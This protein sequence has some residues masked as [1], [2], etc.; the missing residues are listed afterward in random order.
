VN[1]YPE[2]IKAPVT[3]GKKYYLKK[4]PG[5][6][7][8][9][10][11]PTGKAQ[12]FYYWS[13]NGSYYTAVGGSV[14]VNGSTTPL[15]NL[16][17]GVT[18]VG[19]A[20]YN[21]TNDHVLFVCDGNG[22]W[23]IDGSNGVTPIA[24]GGSST[25]PSPHIP[26]PVFLDGYIFLP[27]AGSQLIYNSSLNDPTGW[28]ADG[29]IAA[30]MFPDNLVG[31]FKVQNYIAAVGTNSIEWLYDNANSTGSPLL[32]NAP[33]VSQFGSPSL[34]SINQT[35]QE[36]ITLG[37]TGNGG[38]TVWVINGF[39]PSEIGTEPIREALDNEGADISQSWAY[40]I[41]CAGHKWYVLNLFL[42]QRCLVYDFEEQMWHEWTSGATQNNFTWRFSSDSPIGQPLFMAFNGGT[43]AQMDP[44]YYEDLTVPIQCTVITSKIDFDTI[45]RKRFYRLSVVTDA[46][47]GDNNVPM[48]LTWSDD[49]YNTWQG[50][51]TLYLN[52]SYPTVT[53]MGYS[54]RRAFQFSFVQPYPLRME[55]F[56]VDIVQEVRR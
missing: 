56:E 45:M 22:A 52:A 28:P 5:L 51:F 7:T 54:R 49:D 21:E 4:R 31:I 8:L 9:M 32:R 40:T 16:T 53:Q 48:T 26:T 39:Q 29:F 24:T 18:P 50:N 55:S 19:W 35:E 42:A 23:V 36:L 30:E 15:F 11:V 10:T 27:G 12:G 13:G 14:Y 17:Q 46:P 1:M 20:E 2:L 47:N 33:A 44:N 3:D 6:N 38:W 37:Q 34:G 43:I 41:Q 25:F